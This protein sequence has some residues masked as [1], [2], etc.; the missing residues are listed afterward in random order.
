M[1][2][3]NLKFILLAFGIVF[4]SSCTSLMYTT[5]DVLRPA[6]VVF[7]ADANNLLIVNNTITQP[8]NIGHTT[9]LLNKDPKNVALSTDSLA[10]FCLGALTEDIDGKDFFST[11]KFEPNSINT[12]SNFD[13]LAPLNRFAV[14]NLCLSHNSNV[15][16]SLEKIK[17]ND[18]LS[19]YYLPESSSY[20][21]ALEL[22]FETTWSIYYLNNE[23]V[24]SVQFKDTAYWE[25]ESYT[26][27][28]VLINLPKRADALIDG[29][30][31]VGHKTVDRFI[32][33]W[34][35]VDRYFFNSGNK[36]MKLAMDSVYV[37]NWDSAI[38]NWEKVFEK[39]KSPWIQAQAANNIAIAYEISGNLDKA[40]EYAT[41]AYYSFGKLNFA[42]FD[43]FSRLSDYINELNIRKNDILILKKQLGEK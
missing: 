36:Y 29:A 33:Y 17:V 28:N 18:D 19:E 8:A 16:L 3:H 38:S 20:L 13:S 30:L 7:A 31:N 34:D 9:T 10:I 42:D 41:V 2:P 39:T 40:I 21:A 14:K 11:V 26:R 6:K 15:I 5:L 1:K 25:S 35:K 37:K 22:K 32:P 4:L 43:S 27:K 23:K 24:T 12:D